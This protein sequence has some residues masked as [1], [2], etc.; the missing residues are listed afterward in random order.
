LRIGRTGTIARLGFLPAES[1][2]RLTFRGIFF[3]QV[4]V[5]VEFGSGTGH[6]VVFENNRVLVN[7]LGDYGVSIWFSGTSEGSLSVRNND[8]SSSG[9]AVQ[10]RAQGGPATV[11]GNRATAPV[12]A[13]SSVGIELN[14]GLGTVRALVANNLVH[15]VA[16]CGSGRGGSDFLFGGDG[17]DRAFGG[18]GADFIDVRDGTNGNDRAFGGP[19]RDSCLRDPGDLR[20]DCP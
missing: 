9:I 4:S 2:A 18:D 11:T 1:P 6:Q 16:G 20:R 17:N 10:L 7:T 5:S 3:R 8:I 12:N 15:D 13:N 14:A 19:G